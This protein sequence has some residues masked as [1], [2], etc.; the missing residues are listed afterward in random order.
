MLLFARRRLRLCNLS[1]ASSLRSRKSEAPAA[2][3]SMG[4]ALGTPAAAAEK[5]QSSSTSCPLPPPIAATTTTT[6]PSSNLAPTSPFSSPVAFRLLESPAT[7]RAL[8]PKKTPLGEFF[9]TVNRELRTRDWNANKEENKNSISTSFGTHTSF[10]T[11]K[12]LAA[13]SRRPRRPRPGLRGQGGQRARHHRGRRPR[14][15]RGVQG[16]PGEAPIP[17]PFS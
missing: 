11:T 5:R 14:L 3:A 13:P 4:S 10:S 2:R 6:A 9:E 17:A 15:H 8:L 16:A 7:D 12:R 1:V